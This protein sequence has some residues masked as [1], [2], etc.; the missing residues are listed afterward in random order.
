MDHFERDKILETFSILVDTRE[1]DTAAARRRYASFGCPYQRAKLNYG[2]YTAQ[3]VIDGKTMYSVNDPINPKVVIERKMSLDELAM[4]FGRERKRFEREFQ[5]AKDSGAKI[6][7][8]IENATWENLLG[9]KYRSKLHPKAFFASITAW[10]ARYNTEVI[11]CKAESSGRII[12]EILY[13]ELKEQL[14]GE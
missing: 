6:Y 14:N 11:M 12:G 8:L 13:R 9:G 3:C 1:Q 10:M 2:D 4:C 5:R 7:L